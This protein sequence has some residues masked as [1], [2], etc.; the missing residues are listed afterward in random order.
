MGQFFTPDKRQHEF[1]A[2]GAHSFKSQQNLV[3]PTHVEIAI[4]YILGK[5]CRSFISGG[6]SNSLEKVKKFMSIKLN[7]AILSV[8][9]ESSKF[10]ERF[11]L[12]ILS[13]I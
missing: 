11:F 7:H 12:I 9:C 2:F 13:E 1:I 3:I 6:I 4:I 8:P 5:N 10:Y